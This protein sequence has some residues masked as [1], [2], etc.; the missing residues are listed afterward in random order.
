MAAIR[1]N[2]RFR[3]V[4]DGTLAHLR[5]HGCGCYP[6][7]DGSLLGVIAA[8]ARPRRILELGTALGYST[9]WF[10]HGAPDASIDTIEFDPDHVRLARSHI[11]DAGYADRVRVREGAFE[12]VLPT[13][14]PGYDLAFFDGFEPTL[15]DLERLGDLLRPR[16]VLITTNLDFGGEARPYRER[17]ADPQQW[18]TTFAVEDG[19]TAISIR[20]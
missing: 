9:L 12:A 5:R 6:F 1:R 18:L 16:G 13:L 10:A 8:A 15:R 20:L 11:A 14:D 3:A 17:L 4:R 19:R 7:F 2:D